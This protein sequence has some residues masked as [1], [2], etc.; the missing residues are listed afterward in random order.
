MRL[1]V[2]NTQQSVENSKSGLSGSAHLE[3]TLQKKI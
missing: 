2:G 3:K 1:S